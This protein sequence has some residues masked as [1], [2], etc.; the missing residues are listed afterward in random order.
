MGTI[1]IQASTQ[2]P[3]NHVQNP[4]ILW[5]SLAHLLW[6]IPCFNCVRWELQPGFLPTLT[7]CGF[8]G[9]DL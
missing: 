6:G 5:A 4:L 1:L 9:S 3:S 8:W 7:L 2:G